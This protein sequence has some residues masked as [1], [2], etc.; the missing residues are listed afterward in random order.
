MKNK[1]SS[2]TF[3]QVLYEENFLLIGFSFLIAHSSSQLLASLIKGLLMP[4]IVS[5]TDETSW[6]SATATIG[7]VELKWGEPLADL[8]HF[9]VVVVFS[10]YAYKL[11]KKGSKEEG[12]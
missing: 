2:K 8:I 10:V 4:I 6:E 12:Q 5:I 11:L 3:I 7:G 9:A 1:H